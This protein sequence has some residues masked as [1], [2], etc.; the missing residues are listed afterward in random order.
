M[1]LVLS[2][3]NGI[4]TNGTAHALIPDSS[5]RVRMP[6]QPSFRV[7]R[8][9]GNVSAGNVVVH[10]YTFHNIGSHYN[11]SN[12]RFTAPIAGRYF[13]AINIFTGAGVNTQVWIRVNGSTVGYSLAY[14]GTYTMMNQVNVLNL[15]VND[16][17]DV[18]I[19]FGEVYASGSVVDCTFSGQLLS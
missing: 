2:G 10:G 18:Y 13:I 15:N 6:L 8:D 3:T 14:G 16:Y 12:G 9:A 11:T 4:S 1:P 19:N 17:V 7:G 5:G